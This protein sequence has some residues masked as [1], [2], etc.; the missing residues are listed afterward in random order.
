MKKLCLSIIFS[1]IALLSFATTNPFVSGAA[2]NPN[3]IAGAAPYA[4]LSFT[5]GNT[6]TDPISNLDVDDNSDPI[7]LSVSLKYGTYDNVHYPDA[8]S[9][10]GGAYAT[11]FT[12]T[13]NPVTQSYQ[14]LQ[15]QPI[16]A[17]A[18]GQITI[19]YKALIGSYTDATSA[20]GFN[21]N[22]AT[23]GNAP[24]GTGTNATT[25]D[26]TVKFTYLDSPLPV[27]LSKFT[28]G[29]ENQIVQ[30]N[31]TTT[32]E[33]NAERFDI[34]R[35]GDAKNWATIGEKAA[36]GD[37]KVSLTYNFTDAAPLA[38]TNYYRLKMIDRDGSF[39]YSSVKNV[40]FEGG[41]SIAIYPNPVSNVMF[42]NTEAKNVKGIV[43]ASINGTT[44]YKAANVS[45]DGI[46]VAN[47]SNG[48]Y[49][50]K[51]TKTDGTVSNH[52]IVVVK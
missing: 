7:T 9:A 1:F 11:Y 38:S 45:A 27:T 23:N 33:L 17:G 32:E 46:N 42:L 24:N 18:S 5:F 21:V 16:P 48:T 40:T 35:S 8:L 2:I 37:S 28:A 14:G 22:L 10:I 47:L 15:N 13:F 25:D 52:K 26:N 49:V 41:K 39:A 51:V 44:V 20:N 6:G 36:A 29:K 3:P 30:L 19:A 4:I 31:W 34:Q 12:W 43:I 50:V